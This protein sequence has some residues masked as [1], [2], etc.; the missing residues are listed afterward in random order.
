MKIELEN[1][2]LGHSELTDNIYA[3]KLNKAMNKWL[4]K[5]DVTNQFLDCVIKRWEN[6]KETITCGSSQWEITCKKIK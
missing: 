4:Q 2:K 1:V 6:K 5:V 3:G